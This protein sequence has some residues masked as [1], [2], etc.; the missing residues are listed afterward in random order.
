MISGLEEEVKTLVEKSKAFDNDKKALTA[1]YEER[2]KSMSRQRTTA[3]QE[4]A[5]TKEA[6]AKSQESLDKH[7]KEQE[8]TKELQEEVVKLKEKLTG[9]TRKK[10]E[11]KKDAEETKVLIN[12][13]KF[14][15][16]EAMRER[17]ILAAKV[18]EL[19]EKSSMCKCPGS[20]APG[21]T[22]KERTYLS[23][24]SEKPKLLEELAKKDKE[25]ENLK[26]SKEEMKKNLTKMVT[27]RNEAFGKKSKELLEEKKLSGERAN[28]LAEK[29]KQLAEVVAKAET[30]IDGLQRDLEESKRSAAEREKLWTAADA[31]CAKI[32]QLLNVTRLDEVAGKIRAKDESMRE[33]ESA[34]EQKSQSA[35]RSEDE[36]AELKCRNKSMVEKLLADV[37]T[38][39]GA[40]EQSDDE[41]TRKSLQK[42][43]DAMQRVESEKTYE[44]FYAFTDDLMTDALRILQGFRAT[45]ALERRTLKD[46]ESEVTRLRSQS[47]KHMESEEELLAT[48]RS[49]IETFE[50]SRPIQDVR[51]AMSGEK[52]PISFE[53]SV[54]HTSALLS[55]MTQ[56]LQGAQDEVEKLQ[57]APPP[58]PPQAEG[59]QDKIRE[60]EQSVATNQ[61]ALRVQIER[62]EE[63]RSKLS[64]QEEQAALRIAELERDNREIC[65]AAVSKRIII[66]DAQKADEMVKPKKPK[67]ERP[68]TDPE[69]MADA[70]A[71]LPNV[72]DKERFE[73][74]YVAFEDLAEDMEDIDGL[75]DSLREH[76]REFVNDVIEEDR[77]DSNVLEENKIDEER[78]RRILRKAFALRFRVAMPVFDL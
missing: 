1:S 72:R 18:R 47:A 54:T 38:I 8:D 63:L 35:K 6:L 30:T 4:L 66:A 34:M 29:E 60:L 31:E 71:V 25:M 78:A 19:K 46:A 75:E 37:R 69:A 65:L 2:L 74:L 58:P 68:I 16:G 73:E 76:G 28:L 10:E 22:V 13:T 52:S 5:K 9:E 40:F 24:L 27:T 70:E 11:A 64:R 59:E 3:Q 42:I 7:K 48:V 61:S 33:L 49:V 53:C 62:G 12:R 41:S 57:K 77:V 21:L 36:A 56:A 17:D 32:K 55:A 26:R 44:S 14:A 50:D 67:V 20:D 51:K 45:S 23:L 15:E 43:T 39:L